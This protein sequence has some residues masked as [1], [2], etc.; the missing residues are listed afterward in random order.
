MQPTGG[1]GAIFHTLRVLN[2]RALP[3]VVPPDG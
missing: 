1:I 2:A 3:S